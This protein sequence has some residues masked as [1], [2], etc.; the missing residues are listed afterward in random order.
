MYKHHQ[1]SIANLL[2]YFE[3]DTAILAIILGG[4]VAKG[5]ERADSDIDAIIVT[6]DER[7]RELA[8]SNRLAETIRGHCTYEKGYFDIKYCTKGYLKA[9]DAKGSEPSRNAFLSARILYCTDD[10]IAQIVPRLGVFQVSEQAEKTMSFY[11]GLMLNQ[12]YLW[13]VSGDNPYLRMRAAVDIVLYG[14]RLLLQQN[15]VLFPCHKSLPIA[16]AKL[17]NKPDNIM[18]KEQRLLSTLSDDAK[19]DFVD[20]IL[21]F[22]SFTPPQDSAETLTRF[23][24]DNELWWYKDRPFVPEW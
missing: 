11:S 23:V 8:L 13:R 2:R 24:D 15:E 16:I 17:A 18:E 21:A 1:E 4:S 6:T 9:V 5:L 7:H 10:E 14:Y 20:S 12:G 22:I 19:T 3:G